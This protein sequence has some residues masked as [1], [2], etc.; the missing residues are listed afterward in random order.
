MIHTVSKLGD[1]ALLLRDYLQIQE[2]K[3]KKL[4]E[5]VAQQVCYFLSKELLSIKRTNQSEI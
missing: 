4:L 5:L 1:N 2:D 3:R